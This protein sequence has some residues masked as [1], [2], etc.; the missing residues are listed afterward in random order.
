MRH[1]G[2]RG[3]PGGHA[4]DLTGDKRITVAVS[5]DP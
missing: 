4:H 5:T 3:T 1:S 2:F